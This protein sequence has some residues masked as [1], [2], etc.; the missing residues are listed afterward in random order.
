MRVPGVRRLMLGVQ[1]KRCVSVAPKTPSIRAKGALAAYYPGFMAIYTTSSPRRTRK[2][3]R[4]LPFTRPSAPRGTRA[5][6][7]PFCWFTS[8]MTSPGCTP[9]SS[10]G[11]ALLHPGHHDALGL[12]QDPYTPGDLRRQLLH[13]HPRP[14]LRSGGWRSRRW[15]LWQLR[16]GELHGLFRLFRIRV[17]ATLEPGGAFATTSGSFFT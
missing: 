15:F 17:S 1:C 16:H 14:L 5:G 13:D 8:R 6:Y 10:H 2:R 9:A 12:G 4:L 7:G 3:T 11:A